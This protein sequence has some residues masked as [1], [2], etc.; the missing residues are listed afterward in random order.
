MASFAAASRA[1]RSARAVGGIRL[2]DSDIARA[3]ERLTREAS[4]MVLYAHAMR[5]FL[6]AALLAQRDRQPV[7]EEALY[8]GCVLHDIGLTPSHEHQSR[9]FEHVSADVAVDLTSRYGWPAQRRND[10][11]RAIVLHMAAEVGASES[12]EARMLE[13]GVAL[14]VTGH[15]MSELNRRARE[16]ILR[17]FPRGP[18]KREFSAS[19]MREADRKPSC[20]A[21][22]LVGRGLIG[23]I[24]DAPIPDTP[25]VMP[26]SLL[27]LL[28]FPVEAEASVPIVPEIRFHS[29]A[30][31]MWVAPTRPT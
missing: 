2:P 7:D 25:H 1:S 3:A 12:A 26:P 19:I 5:S 21:A 23:R 15:R 29:T 28:R 16:E 6:F 17:Q 27:N 10:L 30:R 4:S 18:F 8:F 13:A 14:D 9:P 22:T 11:G 31:T 20:T 24:R